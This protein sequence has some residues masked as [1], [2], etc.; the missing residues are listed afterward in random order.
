MDTHE[1][2]KR[3]LAQDK[4][5]FLA[6]INPIQQQLY[7]IAWSYMGNQDDSLDMVQ[8]AIERIFTRLHTLREP[9]YFR[10]WAV[11]IL[12]NECK[13]HLKKQRREVPGEVDT[14]ISPDLT[15][16]VNNRL[17]L[18]TA[19]SALGEKNREVLVLR[20]IKDYSIREIAEILECPLGTVKSRIH[21]GLA[22]LR[23]EMYGGD[24]CEV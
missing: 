7:R 19:L 10:T 24:G 22:Q 20:Y 8:N 3:A 1:L 11:R 16:S 18:D 14:E 5:A 23:R 6:L 12:I 9:Q 4:T 2:V 17:D 15:G 21:H 13:S